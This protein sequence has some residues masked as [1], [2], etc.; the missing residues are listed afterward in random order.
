MVWE[1]LRQ[2]SL[3]PPLLSLP[4]KRLSLS[5]PFTHLVARQ[6][7]EH[8]SKSNGVALILDAEKTQ[9]VLNF[10]FFFPF[11]EAPF[12]FFFFSHPATTSLSKNPHVGCRNP[13]VLSLPSF[14]LRC[15]VLFPFSFL[16]LPPTWDC[17]ERSGAWVEV[18][19]ELETLSGAR[20]SHLS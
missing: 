10:F 18:K 9:P 1:C 20:S 14:L 2:T 15:C 12:S 8:F 6:K 13:L 16:S 3:S 5:S 17:A 11:R 7:I 19:K 4:S